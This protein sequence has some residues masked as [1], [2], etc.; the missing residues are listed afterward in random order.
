[1]L[2]NKIE[3][4]FQVISRLNKLK[5]TREKLNDTVQTQDLLKFNNKDTTYIVLTVIIAVLFRAL[6]EVIAFP[7]PI[8]Y[9]VINYYIPYNTNFE[10]NWDM[11]A[12]QFPL[13][14]S[15]LHMVTISSMLGPEIVVRLS[16]ILVFGIFSISVYQ[17]SRKL[18]SLT[19]T[20][21]FFVALFVIFQVSVLR[22][23]WDLYRDMVAITALLFAFSYG[24]N[25]N[26]MSTRTFILVT[27]LCLLSVLIDRM[28]GALLTAS[29]VLYSTVT[30]NRK[31]IVLTGITSVIYLL[32]LLQG[33]GGIAYN[34]HIPGG[35]TLNNSTY[36]PVN[37]LILFVLTN[38]LLIPTGII[39][40]LRTGYI[41]LKIPLILSLIL[42]FSWVL[43]PF[44]AAVL[45]DRWTFIFSIFLSFFAGYGFINLTDSINKFRQY[46]EII[47]FSYLTPFI[48]MAVLFAISSNDK[49]LSI[50][51]PFHDYVGQFTPMT[52][53]YNSISIPESK[54]LK[55]TIDWLNYN[56][57]T[58]SYIFGD[59]HW[60]GWMELELKDR[61]YVYYPNL[62]EFISSSSPERYWLTMSKQSHTT[63]NN[64]SLVH[65]DRI[66]SVYR[67]N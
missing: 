19:V 21:S 52:M 11:I 26:Q 23:S 5:N 55:L 39:G 24:L 65:T 16:G 15:L 63:N 2:R 49:A 51:A 27:A 33:Y 59:K 30:K 6:P 13:Y 43:M 10:K 7:F 32:A 37:L 22:T 25:K 1:L 36:D 28:I 53:Q 57:P 62:S 14:L 61:N 66:F 44:D 9:D 45:P 60:R 54:S 58:G 31:Y 18:L 29:L 20:Q 35:F 67:L 38:L 34:L 8:G 50:Y 4:K 56:T 64:S 3:F 48:I 47:I 12:N 41:I 42:S 17:A 40:F 46:K